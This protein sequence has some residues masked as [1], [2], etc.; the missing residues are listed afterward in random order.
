MRS[1]GGGRG[2]RARCT[3]Q[4]AGRRPI[5]FST[6][7]IDLYFHGDCP[8]PA[9]LNLRGLGIILV[10]N[11]IKR[12]APTPSGE[13]AGQGLLTCLTPSVGTSLGNPWRTGCCQ[14]SAWLS[15]KQTERNGK[16]L[17]IPRVNR[18]WIRIGLPNC[19]ARY[20][21]IWQKWQFL[22]IVLRGYWIQNARWI[23]T[24][25]AFPA[26]AV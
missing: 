26:L 25:L 12:L 13:R 1:K 23:I 8:P 15:D 2:S 22:A 21:Q 9:S 10:T 14:F 7:P 3:P 24:C 4:Q 17:A 5:A 19:D 11:R 6:A 18:A 16:F 20:L